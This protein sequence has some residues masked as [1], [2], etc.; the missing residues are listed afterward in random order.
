MA[1]RFVER[2]SYDLLDDFSSEIIL[3]DRF[4]EQSPANVLLDLLG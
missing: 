4:S 3:N 2:S 1:P